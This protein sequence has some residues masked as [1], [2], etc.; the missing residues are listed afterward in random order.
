M[1][2]QVG[3]QVMRLTCTLLQLDAVAHVDVIYSDVASGRVIKKTFKHHLDMRRRGTEILQK[4]LSDKKTTNLVGDI[5]VN[6][7]VGR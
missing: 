3:G 7:V 1:G 2:T 5:V 6:K 4:L